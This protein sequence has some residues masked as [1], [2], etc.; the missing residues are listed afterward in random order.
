M[1]QVFAPFLLH[2]HSSSKVL[3]VGLA[4]T[5]L[6]LASVYPLGAHARFKL[7]KQWVAQDYAEFGQFTVPVPGR[8]LRDGAIYWWDTSENA[9]YPLWRIRGNSITPITGLT[10]EEAAFDRAAIFNVGEM[11]VLFGEKDGVSEHFEIDGMEII[12][13]E[14][15][16]GPVP[17][18]SEYLWSP[19]A[20]GTIISGRT[21]EH[22]RELWFMDESGYSLIADVNEGPESSHPGEVGWNIVP[23]YDWPEFPRGESV[24][25]LL[26]TLDDG[27]TGSE[28]W[29]YTAANGSLALIGDLVEGAEGS[30]PL[31]LGNLGSNLYFGAVGNQIYKSD[32]TFA[33]GILDNSFTWTY[34]PYSISQF[35]F[36]F[37]GDLY[38]WWQPHGFDQHGYILRISPDDTVK[39]FDPRYFSPPIQPTELGFVGPFDGE[40]QIVGEDLYS[41]YDFLK[42]VG[43][44]VEYSNALPGP[45]DRPEII[46]SNGSEL[47]V[48]ETAGT[49]HREDIYCIANGEAVPAWR[50][51]T[52]IYYKAKTLVVR[53]DW[54]YIRVIDVLALHGLPGAINQLWG[55]PWP[56]GC[57]QPWV[58][59]MIHEA[60]F[61]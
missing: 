53:G 47:L 38:P 16:L 26:F 14:P 17:F 7:I 35:V 20:T 50:K 58:E 30:H 37:N 52:D 56:G 13:L 25:R 39:K 22:G 11:V 33:S 12:P 61:E 6:F 42:I 55:M 51:P 8:P 24:S 4:S 41:P 49:I 18:T 23:I 2:L 28:P 10:H 40:V 29:V 9:P 57:Q 1:R 45:M 19:I 31:W 60:G 21:A 34:G 43:D 15:R 3:C 48:E 36:E 44:E 59:D 27:K 54:I 5:F 32:G 46:T